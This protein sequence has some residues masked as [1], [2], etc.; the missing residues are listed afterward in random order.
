MSLVDAEAFV[1]SLVI[2][3]SVVTDDPSVERV[4]TSVKLDLS[5]ELPEPDRRTLSATCL[6]I[7]FH[8]LLLAAFATIHWTTVAEPPRQAFASIVSADDV[9]HSVT[10]TEISVADDEEAAASGA[11]SKLAVQAVVSHEQ[12]IANVND[13][14]AESFLQ[15]GTPSD[16]MTAEVSIAGLGRSK[17]NGSGTGED[18]DGKASGGDGN[19]RGSFFGVD[20]TGDKVV[21]IIDGSNSMIEAFKSPERTRLGRVKKELAASIRSLA[22]DQEWYVVFFNSDAFP[23]PADRYLTTE[24]D[25]RETYLQWVQN[26]VP[27]GGTNPI[28]AIQG[29]LQKLEPD[30]VFLL[31]DG[32]FPPQVI[33]IVDDLNKAETVIH[34]I[35][36]GDAASIRSTPSL[37]TRVLT[38][39]AIRN[40]GEAK[41]IPDAR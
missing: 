19:G 22:D 39:L 37:A 13:L 6:S 34:T 18:G 29:T 23:I 15:T 4:T 9:E 17:A 24:E 26:F 12:T 35:G 20:I 10:E 28:P 2:D 41:F 27:G 3:D 36:L 38:E 33:P 32:E 1:S 31:T 25:E 5:E 7:W 8:V 16:W 21:Y 11:E 30:V 14:S 40:N